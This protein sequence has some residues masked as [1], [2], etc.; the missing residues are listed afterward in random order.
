V[1][2]EVADQIRRDFDTASSEAERALSLAS[3]GKLSEASKALKRA[4]ERATCPRCDVELYKGALR[5]SLADIQRRTGD[6]KWRSTLREA[7]G[8]LR[9]FISAI[10]RWR[11]AVRVFGG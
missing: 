9:R 2:R 4:A 3:E 1:S 6:P 7:E 8:E 5:L 11:S 10:P